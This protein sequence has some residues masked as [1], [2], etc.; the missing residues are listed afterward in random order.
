MR[1]GPQ[2]AA[3]TARS[4]SFHPAGR[5]RILSTRFSWRYVPLACPSLLPWLLQHQRLSVTTLVW[6]STALVRCRSLETARV[7]STALHT[8]AALMHRGRCPPALTALATAPQAA[9]YPPQTS[10]SSPDLLPHSSGNSKLVAPYPP[11]AS[12]SNCCIHRDAARRCH[13]R[14]THSRMGQMGLQLDAR[15]VRPTH[16]WCR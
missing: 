4:I 2:A 3:L 11:Q 9:P 12:P 16:A 7:F 5:S 6:C 10:P 1:S 8:P 14:R 13:R 15:G